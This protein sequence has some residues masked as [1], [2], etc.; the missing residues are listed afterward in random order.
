[1]TTIR[2]NS[3][4]AQLSVIGGLL[5]TTF[6]VFSLIVSTYYTNKGFQEVLMNNWKSY[7]HQTAQMVDN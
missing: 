4:F 3:L 7:Q 6:I 1:M 2:E 5:A